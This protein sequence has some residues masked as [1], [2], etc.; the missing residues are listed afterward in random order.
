M[1]SCFCGA[2]PGGLG[3]CLIVLREH[4]QRSRMLDISESVSFCQHYRL[5]ESVV[6]CSLQMIISLFVGLASAA[7][8]V[9]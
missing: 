4:S 8:S 5:K 2:G 1:P 3:L 6:L 7:R 9:F